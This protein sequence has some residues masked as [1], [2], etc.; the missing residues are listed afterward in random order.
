MMK[1][2][3]L[4][5]AAA[6]LVVVPSVSHAQRSRAASPVKFSLDAGIAMPM[7]DWGDAVGTGLGI[8]VSGAKQM[9]GSPVFL[10]GELGFNYYMSKDQG[11]GLSTKGNQIG[12]AFD[13]GYSFPSS[14]TVKPYVLGGLN[15][16]RTSLTAEITNG[17][18]ASDNSG[19]K[20]G[21]NGGVGMRFK[22]GARVAHV[23]GRYMNQG[24]WQGASIA[25]FPITFGVEF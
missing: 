4:S 22:M 3:I 21:F 5:I 7:S 12:G 19:A 13:L 1:R 25:S 10:R 23:E 6:A 11:G 17:G 24:T 20:F 16:H 15:I 18:S 9:T 14:S 2:A 8:G